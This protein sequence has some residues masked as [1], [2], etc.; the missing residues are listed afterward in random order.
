MEGRRVLADKCIWDIGW[1]R[2]QKRGRT[3]L[4]PLCERM[5]VG[6]LAGRALAEFARLVR[7][8]GFAAVLEGGLESAE[9]ALSR[10]PA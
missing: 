9:Q 6:D 1:E 5:R 7:R 3:P 8:F 2:D 4:G 10:P